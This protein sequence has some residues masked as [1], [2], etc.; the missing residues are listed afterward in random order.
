MVIWL[1]EPGAHEAVYVA[2]L[3]KAPRGTNAA[4]EA[5][6]IALLIGY[7]NAGGGTNGGD[8]HSGAFRR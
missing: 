5:S 3:A 7:P 6:F 4:H 2:L 8:A 1:G